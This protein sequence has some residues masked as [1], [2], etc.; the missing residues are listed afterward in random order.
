ML[1]SG[2]FWS[3]VPLLLP[4]ALWVKRRTPRFSAPLGVD[5][6]VVTA[7]GV[8]AAKV[9]VPTLRLVGLGDSIIAGV[10]APTAAEC[11]T[12]RFAQEI[13]KRRKISVEWANVGRIGATTHRV[14]HHLAQRLPPKPADLLLISAGVNDVTSLRRRSEWSSEIRALADHLAR[15]SPGATALFLGLPPMHVFPALPV[16]LRQALG[17][18]ARLFDE[19]L[20]ETLAAHPTARHVPLTLEPA[21]GMFCAD[22]FHPSAATYARIA[23][24]LAEQLHSPLSTLE[25]TACRSE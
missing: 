23:R 14:L 3:T 10:G 11:L 19:K 22:G 12:A 20:A 1:R 5:A 8:S 9:A 16:P 17:L 6:G 21:E 25:S 2:L 7:P 18:R 15:H 24:A 13:N 4:Q